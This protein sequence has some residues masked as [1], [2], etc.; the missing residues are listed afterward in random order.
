M[1]KKSHF[2]LYEKS[3]EKNREKKTFLKNAIMGEKMDKIM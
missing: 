1:N 2:V 3:K